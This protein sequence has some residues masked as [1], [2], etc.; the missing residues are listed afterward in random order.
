MP[1]L[2]GCGMGMG[3]PPTWL[4]QVS[5][6]LHMTTLTTGFIYM[7]LKSKDYVFKCLYLRNCLCCTIQCTLVHTCSY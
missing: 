1:K 7:V 5:P 2:V 6:L 4:Q 3:F